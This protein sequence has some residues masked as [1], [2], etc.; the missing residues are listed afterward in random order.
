MRGLIA[1]LVLAGVGLVSAG[2]L[3]A[4][5][6]VQATG[7][8]NVHLRVSDPAAASEW[9][10]KYLGAAKAPPPFSVQFGRTLV[11]F[12]RTDKPEPSDGSVIDHI[13]LSYADLKGKMRDFEAGGAKVV[14]PLADAPGLFTYGYIEDPW[15]V[16]IE[17]MQDTELLGFHHVHLRVP[18]PAATLQWFHD[19]VGGE[20][21][22][23]RGRIDGVRYGD[24]WLLAARSTTRPA[25]S[26]TRAI[27]NLALEFA[28]VE[29]AFKALQARGAKTISEPRSAGPVRYAFVEDPNGIR[30]ELVNHP[31]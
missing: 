10:I 22:K 24:V 16:K 2:Q 21:G 23:L 26:S 17:V 14:T 1:V 13:G 3:A 18:D 12:V 4:A 20:V 11:A 15:G 19:M 28:S 8:H 9:Y 30:L 25:P 5:P 31:R 6:A 29:D 27:Q 7:Y